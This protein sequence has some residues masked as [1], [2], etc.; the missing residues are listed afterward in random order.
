MGLISFIQSL[1]AT[2]IGSIGGDS[3]W[4]LFT[5]FWDDDGIWIDE[6]NWND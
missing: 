5:S 2:T 4:I 3:D 1:H 6:E